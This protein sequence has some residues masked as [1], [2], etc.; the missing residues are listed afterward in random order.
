MQLVSRHSRPVRRISLTPLIDIVFILLLF[1]ILETNFLGL[2]ELALNLPRQEEGTESRQQALQIQV[3]ADGR[4]WLAGQSLTIT[5]LIEHLGANGYASDTPVVL[6]V[7]HAPIERRPF[8][9][10]GTQTNPKETNGAGGL[11]RSVSQHAM[12]SDR[13]PKSAEIPAA[14]QHRKVKPAHPAKLPGG[15]DREEHSEQWKYHHRDKCKFVGRRNWLFEFRVGVLVR[16]FRASWFWARQRL[17]WAW[18][19]NGGHSVS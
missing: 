14:N 19:R 3:F 18:F 11:E 8:Q 16:L 15:D 17:A 1:F 2:G 5:S 10:E 9:G 4:L 13:D 12:E 7:D 6:A